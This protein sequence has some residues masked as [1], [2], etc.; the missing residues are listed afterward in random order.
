MQSASISTAAGKVVSIRLAGA[1]LSFL[2]SSCAP[3]GQAPAPEDTAVAPAPPPPQNTKAEPA[4]SEVRERPFPIETLYTLLVAEVAGSR[5]QYD[6]ALANYHHQAEYTRDAGIAARAT[7]IARF[8]NARRAA[9]SSARLWAELEPDEA[10]A[11][12]T[13]AAE[14]TLAGD[15][16]SALVHAERALELGG[17]APLQSLAAAAVSNRA[18]AER[19]I[20]EFAR[21]A[22]RYPA[23]PEALLAHAMLLRATEQYQPALAIARGV[24]E[25]HPLLMDAPLLESRIL[26]DQG[27]R[28]QALRLLEQLVDRYPDKTRPRL[29]YARLLI[30]E[31]L[32]LARQQF[33]TLVKQRPDDGGLILSL[34]LIRYETGD[35]AGSKPL[36]QRLLQLQQHQSAAHFY[37]GGIEAKNDNALEAVS[38]YR[39]V[40]PGNDYLK[41]ISRGTELLAAAGLDDRNNDWFNELREDH[42]EQ[43]EHFYL[44]QANLLRKYDRHRAALELLDRA[45]ASHP[46]SGRLLYIRALVNEHL[47]Y[48]AEFEQGIRGLLQR[49]PDNATLLNTLG[50]KLSQD[51]ARLDEASSLIRRAFALRP[52]D[53][54]IIDSMGWIE[55]RLGNYPAA[56][57][58][59]QRALEK[60]PD[61]E[62]A[63]HLGEVLWMQGNREQAMEVW[64]KGLQLNPNSQLIPAAIERL[65]I[66]PATE[67][68]ASD[69]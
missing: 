6:L 64:Q 16:D 69:N 41:A 11:H 13:A 12:L 28:Q 68:H 46:Q 17:N 18:V 9:L 36:F 52:D 67:Q 4:S 23:N 33:A 38:H 54:A 44:L 8:L 37:L 1:V 35:L 47:G 39:A 57:E 26:A 50:Y 58:H 14:L 62:I 59:L 7:R 19:V 60:Y 53:P 22:L 30:H 24:R 5:E 40:E 34:A 21:L 25:Q 20:P 10:E 49:D 63:A 42:P 15:L 61:H 45:L 55:Y 43:A 29:Q 66:K 27:D 65:Q 48:D 32:D 2:L 51:D 56:V 31:D 3:V